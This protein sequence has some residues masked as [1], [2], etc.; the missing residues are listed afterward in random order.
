[1][2]AVF[3]TAFFMLSGYSL[4]INYADENIIGINHLKKFYI[5]RIIGVIPMYYVTA[6]LYVIF[7]FAQSC[8]TGKEYSLVNELILAP[9]ELLG[10]QSNFHSIFDYSHNGGTWFI[11]CIL[12]CYLVYPLI[13]EVAKQV[14]YKT[15]IKLVIL[16][17]FILLYAPFIEHRFQTVTIY[18][19]PF[20]RILEF[21]IGILLASMKPQLDQMMVI[22]KY[23]YKWKMVLFASVLMII[24]ISIA[25]YMKIAIGNYMLYSWI[26]LPCFVVIL[27]GLSGVESRRL[28]DSKFISYCSA[29]GYTF[30]LA[31]LFSNQ[32]A[33]FIIRHFNVTNNLMIIILGW[34]ICIA[35]AVVFH[36]VFEKPITRRLKKRY[37]F[38]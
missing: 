35:I 36:E 27:I 13:Q 23:F 29:L 34:A 25:V 5:K 15:K 21:T 24:G 31:Q 30:F 16:L 1:M 7:T 32:I 28:G 17:A 3:M 9:I 14:D 37:L 10:L 22:K 33:K 19:N 6:L 26:C 4:F 11:S 38:N 8:L 18:A 12:M 20:F 2:G